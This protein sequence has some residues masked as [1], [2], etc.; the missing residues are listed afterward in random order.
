MTDTVQTEESGPWSKGWKDIATAAGNLV[1]DVVQGAQEAVKKVTGPWEMPWQDLSSQ[2]AKNRPV[3]PSKPVYEFDTVFSNLIGAE[4]QGKH[5]VGGKLLTSKAGAEGISQ[6]MPRTA[7][8]PGYGV[9]P[10]QD[11]SEAEYKRFGR[12]YLKAMLKEFDGDYEKALAAYN[13]GEGT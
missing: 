13:A 6:L 7:G 8:N 2:A 5:S 12:D 1:Q 3:E 11:K 9:T 4:S 10:I